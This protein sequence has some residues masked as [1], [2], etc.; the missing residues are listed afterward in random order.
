ML[1]GRSSHTRCVH[2]NCL[3]VCGLKFVPLLRYFCVVNTHIPTCLPVNWQQETIKK[4]TYWLHTC[5]GQCDPGTRKV[6]SARVCSAMSLLLTLR[7]EGGQWWTLS[8]PRVVSRVASRDSSFSSK[9]ASNRS[10]RMAAWPLLFHWV[11]E[12]SNPIAVALFGVDIG[13]QFFC[14]SA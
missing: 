9:P 2:T 1:E 14:W 13:R 6:N 12:L 11:L 8:S 5:K 4:R 10:L 7:R 3:L